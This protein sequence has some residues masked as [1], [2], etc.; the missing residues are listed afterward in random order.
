VKG[1]N[2]I[3]AQYWIW[4][5]TVS[6]YIDHYTKAKLIPQGNCTWDDREDTVQICYLHGI[7]PDSKPDID[8]IEKQLELEVP[9]IFARNNSIPSIIMYWQWH[10]WFEYGT[11][12]MS[13]R[14]GQTNFNTC[15]TNFENFAL[16]AEPT[17]NT[18]QRIQQVTIE[19]WNEDG[20][21]AT[22]QPAYH[23]F[24]NDDTQFQL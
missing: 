17:Y 19:I 5:I 1:F 11:I 8:N 7:W 3:F 20:Q 12:R 10:P 22:C 15:G 18:M 21:N 6:Y 23:M 9:T 13:R 24:P 4:D 2:I 14:S 16:L